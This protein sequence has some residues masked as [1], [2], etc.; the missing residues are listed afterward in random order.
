VYGVVPVL[1]GVGRHVLYGNRT[2]RCVALPTQVL[3]ETQLRRV[4][5]NPRLQ[6]RTVVWTSRLAVL[7]AGRPKARPADCAIDRQSLTSIPAVVPRTI[8]RILST[9]SLGVTTFSIRVWPGGPLRALLFI[10]V[11][12]CAF[13]PGDAANTKHGASLTSSEHR[14]LT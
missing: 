14:W 13:A 11:P 7:P 6:V 3:L 10:C 5:T 1:V 9:H 12:R 8:V 4:A 2:I